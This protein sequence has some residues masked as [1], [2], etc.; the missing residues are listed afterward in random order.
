MQAQEPAAPAPPPAATAP[1]GHNW[2][3]NG[4]Q[5]SGMVDAY[6]S[7]NANNPAT[8]KS[9]LHFFDVYAN[10]VDLNMAKFGIE[11]SPGPIGFRLDAG[12]GE[13]FQAFHVFDPNK[14]FRP[15]Q[16]ILQAYV[17][18]KP[19]SWHGIE[20]DGG[21]FYTSAGAE[22]TETQLNWNYSRSLL[23]VLGP[24]YHTGV[25]MSAPIG[26]KFTGGVQLVNG[27]NSL[28]D[29]NTGKTI[30]L[31]GTYNFGKVTWANNYYAGPEKTD[32]NEGYR[33]FYDTSVVITPN[34]ILTS[35][36]NFDYGADRN[37]G[38]GAQV[39]YGI[40]GAARVALGPKF[41]FAPRV[42]WYKDRDGFAT[43]TAQSLKEVTLTGEY[44]L[45]EGII[46]RL[47]YRRDM[48]DKL[49]F[50]KDANSLVKQQSTFVIG[51]VAFF[52]PKS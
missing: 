14:D 52:G 33:H 8:N 22:V 45:H 16:Q 39:F 47:E 27:W 42:E 19:K 51:L 3:F 25:R 40:A 23:F 6:Y 38:G 26:K 1:T 46:T 50:H 49:Y 10:R 20:I 7:Y 18:F 2:T 36:I 43:G 24:F 34:K 13:G 17:S 30:G 15:F 44:K 37:I 12:A 32:T 21:K 28:V 11:Y 9:D 31:N 48:S 5:I 41:A 4:F 35:Y 29:N